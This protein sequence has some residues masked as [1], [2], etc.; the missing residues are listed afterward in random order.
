MLQI[1]RP[2]YLDAERSP[3]KLAAPKSC[4]DLPL[5]EWYGKG[6][7]GIDNVLPAA[8]PSTDSEWQPQQA[9][10]QQHERQLHQQ[11]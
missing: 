5:Q 3:Q 11:Q 9:P 7:E 8:G 4:I 1:F 10:H 6:Q 2:V